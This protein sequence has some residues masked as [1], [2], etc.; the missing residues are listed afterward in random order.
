M[1]PRYGERRRPL[2][3]TRGVTHTQVGDIPHLRTLWRGYV[4]DAP[5]AVQVL[6]G[7]RGGCLPMRNASGQFVYALPDGTFTSG[8]Q[9]A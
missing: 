8:E 2:Q 6:P 7:K 5:L 3:D 1:I 4:I 9:S